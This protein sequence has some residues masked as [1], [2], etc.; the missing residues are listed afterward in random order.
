[1]KTQ[2]KNLAFNRS[3]LVELSN[4]E[5]Y[6]VNGG[7]SPLCLPTIVWTIVFLAN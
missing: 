3:S 4:D 5:L 2:N 6:D 7:S 1:M